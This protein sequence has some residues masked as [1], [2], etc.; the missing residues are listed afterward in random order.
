MG[1]GGP[2]DGTGRAAPKAAAEG[3]GPRAALGDPLEGLDRLPALRP[4]TR[5]HTHA[6]AHAHAHSGQ[7][8]E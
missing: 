2:G 8:G 3:G 7:I 4:I 1:P 5:T 6:H